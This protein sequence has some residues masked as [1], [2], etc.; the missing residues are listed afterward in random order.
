MATLCAL[1]KPTAKYLKH[2]NHYKLWSFGVP[3]ANLRHLQSRITGNPLHLSD[4]VMRMEANHRRVIGWPLRRCLKQH[5]QLKPMSNAVTLGNLWHLQ[6]P[7]SAG[8]PYDLVRIGAHH[9]WPPPS[10]N[11][12]SDNNT[13]RNKAEKRKAKPL[14]PAGGANQLRSFGCERE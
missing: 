5:V 7:G 11:L 10:G 12:F 6:W 1:V 3:V 13:L 2:Y 4:L 14:A 9:L 8:N